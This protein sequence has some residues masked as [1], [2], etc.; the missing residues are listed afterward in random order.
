MAVAVCRT[1]V[2]AAASS[3]IYDEAQHLFMKL[4]A[5]AILVCVLA[6][7]AC[8]DGGD[9]TP[10]FVQPTPTL[11]TDSFTGTVVVGG[12]D[13]HTFNVGSSGQLNV[14]LTA[15]GPPPTIFMGIGVGTPS[16]TNCVLLTNGSTAAPA[17]TAAQL[18]GTVAAGTYCVSVFDI[19]NQTGPVTYAVTL[20]H[21]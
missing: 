4:A 5:S 7:A 17:A 1:L 8:G 11:V 2:T 21:F 13:S 10:N 9:S 15:A 3:F 16:G 6:G 14:T 20:T 19:G 18:S 12:S